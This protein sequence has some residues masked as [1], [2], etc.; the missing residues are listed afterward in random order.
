MEQKNTSLRISTKLLPRDIS[1]SM[2]K[3]P[4]SA[5]DLEEVVLGALMLEKDAL[6]VID[7]LK[8]E[9]F[10]SEA[11][12]EVYQAIINLFKSTNPIDMRTVVNQLRIEG[13]IEIVGGA[14]YI[15][16]L[17]SK[18]ASAANIEYYARV[19]I[20]MAIKRELIQIA[21]QVHQDAYEDTTDVFDL[22]ESVQGHLDNVS[23]SN[24][25]G[26]AVS[27]K[28]LYMSTM[29]Y[30]YESRNDHGITGVRTGFVEMDRISGGWQKPDLI[31]IAGRPGMGK[32]LSLNSGIMTPD[33]WK[34][35]GSIEVDDLIIGSDGRSYPVTGV[36]PQGIK[37]TYRVIFDDGS[38]VICDDSHLWYTNT[39]ADRKIKG[40]RR[41]TVKGILEIRSTLKK[42]TRANHSIPF[43][44]PI[45][46]Q[47]C[48]TKLDPY[49]VGVIIG[50]GC[51]RDETFSISN[52][53][54]DIIRR[55]RERLPNGYTLNKVSGIEYNIASNKNERFCR[56]IPELL[57][58]YSYEKEIPEEYILNSIENRLEL[59]RGLIDTD[60]N[61]TDK[62]SPW[63]EYCTT[64]EKLA[65]QV[66]DLVR[67]L[68]GRCSVNKYMGSYRKDGT[69]KETREYSRLLIAFA[70]GIIPFNSEKHR[71]KYIPKRYSQKFIKDVVYNGKIETQCI[72]VASPDSLFITDG[73][74]LTHN[75][76]CAGELIKNAAIMFK[77][78]VALFSLEMSD[79]Q[80]MQRLIASEAEVD[81]ERLVR[82]N[83]TDM[84]IMAIADKTKQIYDAPIY[85]DDTPAIST[86]ELRAKAR[87]LK[88]EHNIQLIVVDYLQ[89]MRGDKGGNREQEIA[90][91]SRALKSLAKELGIP[92]IAIAALSRGVETRGGDKK[93]QL[94]DLRES[95]QIESDADIVIF[96]YRAEYYKI[97]VDEL[98][99]STQGIIEV[100]TA[101]NRN[102]KTGSVFLKF[103]GKYAK[104]RDLNEPQ[105]RDSLNDR[106]VIDFSQSRVVRDEPMLDNPDDMPF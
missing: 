22:L 63:I 25:K 96:L 77:I 65:E 62:I 35:M 33:G 18:V 72:T 94:A 74:T 68:G 85:I 80:F 69:K 78:P 55:V 5:L 47:S 60:G 70:N 11:N 101:K 58:K 79:R 17:T 46:L 56:L 7:F 71:K 13:K 3:L 41:G 84:E 95:G 104:M 76:A 81:L 59:L 28:E 50:D 45:Q 51:T 44:S 23:V 21:S 19:I 31:I 24:F 88:H 100:I 10:Y 43:I 54:Q 87:K 37:D 99:N 6:A 86:L 105:G 20:E 83:T 30:L 89:L 91:I 64:S 67:G 4:P 26:G 38:E 102:G 53:E 66:I 49:V 14:H 97:E 8:P 36:Y 9:H 29:K 27:A 98:G 73:M 48:K 61:I 75:S 15:A 40:M 93:P 82:G 1:E 2:G 16:E 12:R 57:G 103:I 32:G 90:S 42:G 106:K 92:V 39:R 34:K 52:P